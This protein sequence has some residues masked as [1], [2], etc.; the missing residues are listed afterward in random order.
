MND[1]NALW[2][3]VTILLT[4][5]MFTMVSFSFPHSPSPGS[6]DLTTSP[7]NCQ[8]SPPGG[9][10]SDYNGSGTRDHGFSGSGGERSPEN[11]AAAHIDI[12]AQFLADLRRLG[13]R[14]SGNGD[15]VRGSGAT[16]PDR[17]AWVSIP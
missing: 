7:S 15:L 13:D 6:T 9:S 14:R 1:H 12:R 17:W 11:S 10:G 3:I 4:I 5:I 16:S 8:N 2:F